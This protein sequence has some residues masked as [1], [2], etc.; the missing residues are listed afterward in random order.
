[1]SVFVLCTSKASKEAQELLAL[2]ASCASI[3]TFVLGKQV[4]R[5]TPRLERLAVRTFE[6]LKERRR[7]EAPASQYLYFCTNKAIILEAN[8]PNLLA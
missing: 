5:R 1:M 2:S 6:A 4:K 8:K 7:R 3:C